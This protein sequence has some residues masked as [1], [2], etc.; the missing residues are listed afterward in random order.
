[1]QS[2]P[3]ASGT[4]EYWAMEPNARTGS[5]GGVLLVGHAG[6]IVGVGVGVGVGE[7]AGSGF[8]VGCGVGRPE[9]PV[10]PP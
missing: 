8:E 7:G 1:M 6:G 10:P 2:R 9:P 5:A 4:G 3:C